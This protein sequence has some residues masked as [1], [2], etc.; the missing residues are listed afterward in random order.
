LLPRLRE[1]W[2]EARASTGSS[3][4]EAWSACD[5]LAGR[6]VA[7][8]CAGRRIEGR[9]AGVDP[10]GRLRLVRPD[11]DIAH[12]WSGDVSVLTGQ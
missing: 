2:L 3:L 11:G 7:V 9:A 5:A 8:D 10:D 1:A 12:L 6:R 4:P